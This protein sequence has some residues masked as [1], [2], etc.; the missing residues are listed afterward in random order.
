MSTAVMTERIPETS[1]RLKARITGA[2]YLLTILTGNFAQGFVSGRLVA[3][4]DAAATAANILT[5]RGL[6]QLG[7]AVYLIEM[8]CQIA[9][10]ALFYDL[11][12]PAGRSVSLVAAFLGLTGCI[13]KTFSRLFFIAPLFI[14]GGAHYLSVFSR[15]QLQALALLFVRVNDHGAAMALVFFGFYAPLTGYLIIRSTFLPRILGWFSVIA[16]V[17]WLTFLYQPL[18][19]RLFPYVAALGLLGAVSLMLWLLVFGVNEQRWK[20][21]ASAAGDR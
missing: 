17:G 5:H 16:G 3:D 12:K 6:F 1:P 4:G 10:T 2:L 8:A 7:F 19:Y 9:M 18:G 13:I 15:E 11:L 14:L 21:Q 20:E